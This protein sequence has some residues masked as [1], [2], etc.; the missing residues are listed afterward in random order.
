[1]LLI[2]NYNKILLNINYNYKKIGLTVKSGNNKPKFN[3]ITT[4]LE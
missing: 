2:I 1:M 3:D 4:F